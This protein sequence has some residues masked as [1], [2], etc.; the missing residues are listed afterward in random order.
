MI[1]NKDDNTILEKIGVFGQRKYLELESDKFFWFKGKT[2]I[3]SCFIKEF[4]FLKNVTITDFVQ[5]EEVL[6]TELYQEDF[7]IFFKELKNLKIDFV[8]CPPSYVIFPLKPNNTLGAEFGTVINDLTQSEDLL[9][10]NLHGKHRNVVKKAQ[11]DGV[12]LFTGK[13]H[14]KECFDIIKDTL[15]REGLGFVSLNKY[16]EYCER[17][18]DN[19]E[20]FLV[21]KDGVVQGAG[22]FPYSENAAYY[23]WGGSVKRPHIGSMNF[24]HWKAMMHFKNLNVKNYDFVGVRLNPDKESKLYGIK[25]FKIRFGGPTKEGFIWK[26]IINKPKHF[27]Y[28]L[29]I[30]AK[31]RKFPSDIID[32]LNSGK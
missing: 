17:L 8:S 13:D 1:I 14:K 19:I 27:L 12:E 23:L 5:T 18:S 10:K 20:F 28:K 16:N 26:K 22:V 7:L 31:T 15:D 4:F 32:K 30:L 29:A 25:R 11:K 21:K 9:F 2:F 3:I 6:D 24:L